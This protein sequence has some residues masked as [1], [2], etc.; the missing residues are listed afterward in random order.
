MSG[1]VND[2]KTKAKAAYWTNTHFSLM[3]T[4]TSFCGHTLCT[5]PVKASARG[6]K[7]YQP[8]LPPLANSNTPINST[9]Q[10]S[11]NSFIIAK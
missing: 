3:L 1:N 6:G 10:Q 7:A 4:C 8:P 2:Q 5:R 11:S 9:Y